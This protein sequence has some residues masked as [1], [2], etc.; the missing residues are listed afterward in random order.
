MPK[1]KHVVIIG[2]G[3]VGSAVFLELLKFGYSASL[4]EKEKS[5][6]AH[7]T[8]RNSGVIHSGPYYKPGSNKAR[9]CGTGRKL[10]LEY[11]LD[12]GL[13]LRVTGKVLIAINELEIS[14]LQG[15]LERSRVNGVRAEIIRPEQLIELEPNAFPGQALHV[16]DT[17]VTDFRLVA[18]SLVSDALSLGGAVLL[19]TE[20]SAIRE[21]QNGWQVEHSG[22]SLK[23]DFLINT[24]GLASDKVARLAGV[25]PGVS[26]VPF[27]GEYL[28]LTGK[29]KSL[30]NG[31]IY[32]VPNP[33]LPFLGL[34]LTRML[35]GELHAGPS[36]TL[37][38]GREAYGRWGLN[39]KDLFGIVR[40]P[41]LSKFVWEQRKFATQELYQSISLGATARALQR[42]VPMV[43]KRDLRRVEAGIRAQA[44]SANGKLLDDFVI[45]ALPRQV[46]VLNAPS[47]AA[48]SSLA[49]AS[50]I[51]TLAN[52]QLR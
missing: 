25:D 46:H 2:G 11:L 5:I 51:C 13:P 42:L 39:V 45:K 33:E 22:G 35:D 31:L 30:V 28:S 14:M 47:P 49:I 40:S 7:Q 34:H 26:I 19:G 18:E 36:A 20:V 43:D 1:V 10:L 8:G 17:A 50:E 3:I 9:M 44:L 38:L 16:K 21:I 52:N 27:K 32:P 15:L 23:A 4:L 37:A 24:A 6:G 29:S 12:K 41:G 48:T